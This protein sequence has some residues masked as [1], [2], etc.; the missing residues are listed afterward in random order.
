MRPFGYARQRALGLRTFRFAE[1]VAAHIGESNLT[2]Q[3]RNLAENS[4]F[5]L[6]GFRRPCKLRRDRRKRKDQF[7]ERGSGLLHT[8][9]G[10]GTL[11]DPPGDPVLVGSRDGFSL[12][13]P[14]ASAPG[15]FEPV[16]YRTA[17]Q[18]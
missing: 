16:F 2:L 15:G 9:L 10:I 4:S 17:A 18:A 14:I 3:G 7:F 11:E 8:D 12:E 1:T 5:K 6:P 13:N